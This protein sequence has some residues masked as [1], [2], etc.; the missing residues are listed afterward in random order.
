VLAKGKANDTLELCGNEGV[1]MH[2][3]IGMTDE[4]EIGFFHETSPCGARHVRGHRLLPRSLCG[5]DGVLTHMRVLIAKV[6]H[7]TNTFSPVP[8]PVARFCPDGETLLTGRAAIDFYRGTTSCIGRYL[9][10]ADE[11]GAE[12][13]LPVAARPHRRAVPSTMTHSNCFPG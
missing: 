11:L 9:S 2:G 12:V 13:V 4:H 8:T 5:A 3:G 7:E 10:I 6:S 1:Q